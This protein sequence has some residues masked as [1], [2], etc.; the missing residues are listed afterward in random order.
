MNGMMVLTQ[1]QLFTLT[2][3]G[4]PYCNGLTHYQIVQI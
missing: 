3:V 1:I 2:Q 4:N